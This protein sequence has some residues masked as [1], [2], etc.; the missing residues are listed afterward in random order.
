MQTDD[1]LAPFMQHFP[2]LL[3]RIF[4]FHELWSDAINKSS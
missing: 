3:A 1:L 4:F 2:R